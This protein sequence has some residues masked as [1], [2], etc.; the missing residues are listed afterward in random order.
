[1]WA[2]IAA[3][4]MAAD[5]APVIRSWR[6]GLLLHEEGEYG[7]PA[8]AAAAGVPWVTHAWGS[9][10]RPA[11]DLRALEVEVEASG[12]WAG[13]PMAPAAGLYAHCLLNPCPPFLEGRPPVPRSWPV[14]PSVLGG[15][16]PSTDAAG[17]RACYIGFGTVPAFAGA[18]LPILAAARSALRCGHEVIATTSDPELAESL[19]GLGVDVR[20]FVSLP[21]VLRRCAVAVTH[22]GAGTTL[23]AL[24]AGV[25]VVAVPQGAPSQERMATAVE[26]AAVGICARSAAEVEAAVAAASTDP[27]LHERAAEAAHRIAA[28]P[29]PESVVAVLEAVA[30][31]SLPA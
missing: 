27:A 21:A 19:S 12:V 31:G 1:M 16:P 25:P 29:S 7:G 10:L 8:A 14:R 11:A 3:P 20:R 2:R 23:A 30:S 5:L 6:P 26:R 4:A 17:R 9:P 28:M 18:P 24:A 13:V 15:T 22:G